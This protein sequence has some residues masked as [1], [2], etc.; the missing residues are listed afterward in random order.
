MSSL[1]SLIER[2]DWK[3]IGPKTKLGALQLGERDIT[4][5][6]ARKGISKDSVIKSAN[7]VRIRIGNSIANEWGLQTGQKLCIFFDP[8]DVFTMMMAK[9][10]PETGGFKLSKDI[11]GYG[12]RLKFKWQGIIP[13]DEMPATK[14]NYEIDKGRLIFQIIPKRKSLEHSF[15]R[16]Y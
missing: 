3:R 8:D 13:L 10:A 12:Y 16:S 9:V 14:V 11:N 7:E 2:I 1:A 5:Q 6:F 4:V 15:D